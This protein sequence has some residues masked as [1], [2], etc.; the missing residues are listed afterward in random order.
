[1]RLLLFLCVFTALSGCALPVPLSEGVM[2]ESGTYGEPRR[3]P[4]PPIH[5]AP[6][7]RVSAGMGI[8]AT[9]YPP[10]FGGLLA[11]H[12]GH[13][14]GDS[15]N[16]FYQISLPVPPQFG[17]GKTEWG[18]VA[19]GF[20]LVGPYANGTLRLFGVQYLTLNTILFPN[21]AQGE[22]IL[23]RRLLHGGNSGLSAGAFYRYE[24]QDGGL[25]LAD[26]GP[27][28]VHVLGARTAYAFHSDWLRLQGYTSL[29]YAPDFDV[30]V[31]GFGLMHTL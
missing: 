22:V 7:V 25:L 19:V 27:V 13:E 29:G 14:F 10:S 31:F 8:A 20:G 28:R 6:T 12:Q 5:R 24:L 11:E 9:F 4:V 23:Q 21:L 17:F 26:D 3:L 15:Q 30:P 16:G 18:S 2:F 1:M